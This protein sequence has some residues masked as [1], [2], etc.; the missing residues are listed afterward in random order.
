[1]GA[2]GRAFK[3]PRPDQISFVFRCYF[4]KPRT[5]PKSR[6]PGS[7]LLKTL[8][9]LSHQATQVATSTYNFDYSWRAIFRDGNPRGEIH[10]GVVVGGVW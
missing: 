4:A 1:L 9:L 10:S 5:C 8:E 7:P 6:G 2:G 3:S